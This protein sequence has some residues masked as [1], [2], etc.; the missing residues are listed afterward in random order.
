MIYITDLN[1]MI[2]DLNQSTLFI[3][4]TVYRTDGLS[5]RRFIESTVYRTDSLSNRQFV[6]PTVC[7]TD[8]LSNRQ[9]V[10][11]TVCRTDSLSNRQFVEPTV[12]RTDSLSNRQFVEPT[13]CQTD[14]LSKR[15]LWF[16]CCKTLLRHGHHAVMYSCSHNFL[17]NFVQM[18][19]PFYLSLVST[20]IVSR[21]KNHNH[22]S[23][24][25][26]S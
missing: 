14:S 5:N 19:S 18:Q 17:L 15:L 8:S 12:C 13:V 26:W 9:F 23:K 21:T 11:P 20:G 25:Q 2:Y 3:E 16:N 24:Q 6:E 4:P 22:R 7:R 10:E 1:Q